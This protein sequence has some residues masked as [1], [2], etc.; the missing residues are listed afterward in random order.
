VVTIPTLSLKVKKKVKRSPGFP[1]HL[2]PAVITESSGI[3]IHC[4]V[5]PQLHLFVLFLCHLL[6][7]ELNPIY[8][9]VQ[10]RNEVPFSSKKFKNHNVFKTPYLQL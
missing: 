8:E 3:K 6:H 5:H 4:N 1:P 2:S 7:R 10:F 9:K